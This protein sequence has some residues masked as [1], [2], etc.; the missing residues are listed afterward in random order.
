[1]VEIEVDSECYKTISPPLMALAEK[2]LK[3]LL[4]RRPRLRSGQKWLEPIDVMGNYLGFNCRYLGKEDVL[5]VTGVK[6]LQR[7]K[8]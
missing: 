7:K 1:M 3:R 2:E 4:G 8:R 6:Y 5:L